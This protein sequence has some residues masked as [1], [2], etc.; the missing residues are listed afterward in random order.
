MSKNELAELEEAFNDKELLL[1]YIT[2]IK[3]GM[4]ATKAYKEL[5]P[6]V[7]D[8][9]AA[10]LG[11]RWLGRINKE[12]VLSAYKLDVESYMNQLKEGLEA[13]R[14]IAA[15]IFIDKNGKSVKASNEGAIE[16]PDHFV[17]RFYHDKLGRLLGLEGKFEFKFQQQNNYFDVK[18]DQVTGL[19]NKTGSVELGE[20]TLI[21]ALIEGDIP[22]EESETPVGV[23]TEE[24]SS[25]N[26]T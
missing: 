20:E 19:T 21:E 24:L 2:W 22:R 18:D 17:R 3:S 11:M 1:F 15:A 12:M 9:S 8:G 13:T 23:H 25:A 5:H 7:T 4:N 16:V 6:H 26:S 14:P 10:V